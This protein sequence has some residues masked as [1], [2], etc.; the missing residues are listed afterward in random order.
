MK[1]LVFNRVRGLY[2]KKYGILII[3]NQW[4]VDAWKELPIKTV[5]KGFKNCS[6]SSMLDGTEDDILWMNDPDNDDDDER[7]EEL[8]Y[9]DD[10]ITQ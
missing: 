1:M 5:V 3:A 4:I 2:S 6:I 10:C 9:H 7:E 8:D